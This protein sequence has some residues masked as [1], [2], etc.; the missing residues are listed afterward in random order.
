[1][2]LRA[3]TCDSCGGAV[4]MEAGADVPRCLFCG[5][6]KLSQSEDLPEEVDPPE[7][8]VAFSVSDED[9]DVAFRKFARSSFWYPKDIRDARLELN[10]L[11]LPAWVFSGTIETHYAAIVRAATRSGGRPFAGAERTEMT[12]VLVPSSAALTRAELDAISPFEMKDA[13]PFSVST[14]E[15]PFELGSLTRTAATQQALKHMQSRHRS[16][17]SATLK[18]RKLNASA[19][20]EDLSGDPVLLPIFIGAYRRREEVYRIVING[21]TGKLI[22]KAPISWTKVALVIFIVGAILFM[23]LICLGLTGAIA[24]QL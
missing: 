7:I 20:H 11:Y 5:S 23:A 4:A 24:S 8:V 19:I 3:V 15:D 6:L 22:G 10:R 21:Q 14:L 18:A 17:L 16:A 9:A 2:T 12:G 1:M 13:N